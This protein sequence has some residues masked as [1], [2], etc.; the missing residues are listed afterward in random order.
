MTPRPHAAAAFSAATADV[1]AMLRRSADGTTLARALR[2]AVPLLT[3]SSVTIECRAGDAFANDERLTVAVARVWCDHLQSHALS[4]VEFAPG[5]SERE[6]LHFLV[7]L[8]GPVDVLAFKRLWTSHGAW[9]IH[10]RSRSDTPATRPEMSDAAAMLIED[11][12]QPRT[13]GTPTRVVRRAQ[14]EQLAE[15]VRMGVPASEMD[16]LGQA[17]RIAGPQA[18]AVLLEELAVAS[19]GAQ[20]RW[21]FDALRQLREGHVHLITALQHPEWFVVRNAAQLLGELRI[22]GATF[23]L[24]TLLRHQ[25]SRVRSAAASSLAALATVDAWTMLNDAPHDSA[26]DVRLVLWEARATCAMPPDMGRVEHALRVETDERVQ[27]A[28]LQCI[29]A[30]PSLDV[31]GA[32]LRFCAREIDGR[33]NDETVLMGLELLARLRPASARP[34]LRRLADENRWP[35]IAAA[36]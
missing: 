17:L 28:I 9:H 36:G 30:F 26:P 10:V 11:I 4:A 6:L 29:A 21:L 23:A 15:L 16:P 8:S 25:D 12:L 18:T 3:E 5:V 33:R 22:V 32:L 35:E 1:L 13:E 27:R 2:A 34:L 31:S 20:R 7:L 14:I 24:G 19:S